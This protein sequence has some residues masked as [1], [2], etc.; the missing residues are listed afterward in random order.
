SAEDDPSRP[1]LAESN[2]FQIVVAESRNPFLL[3]E[4]ALD[5]EYVSFLA[6]LETTIRDGQKKRLF[7]SAFLPALV[8]SLLVDTLHGVLARRAHGHRGF[9]VNENAV[10]RLAY[11]IAGKQ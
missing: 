3:P 1:W 7:S 11:H 10:W 9:N 5:T 4:A 2:V 8:A 6:T